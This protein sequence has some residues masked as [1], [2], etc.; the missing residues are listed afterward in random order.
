MNTSSNIFHILRE[1][2]T[3]TIEGWCGQ[4][5]VVGDVPVKHRMVWWSDLGWYIAEPTCDACIL[6]YW[7]RKKE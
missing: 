7:A 3:D 4:H 5:L 2:V 1:E 6:L